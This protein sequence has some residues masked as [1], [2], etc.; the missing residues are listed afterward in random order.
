MDAYEKLISV[1]R[2]EGRRNLVIYPLRQA[3][4]TSGTT[5]TVGE[6]ELDDDDL[7]KAENLELENGDNVLIAQIS[8]EKWAIICKVVD[9]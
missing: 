5:C 3:T 6:Q 7:V 4:M 8:E 2:K 9:V 1:M